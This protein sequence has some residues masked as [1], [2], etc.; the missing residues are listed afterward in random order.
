MEGF[1]YFKDSI[2]SCFRKTTGL[3]LLPRR[4]K[5]EG[6]QAPGGGEHEE[7]QFLL[8]SEVQNR[9]GEQSKFYGK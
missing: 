1:R 5:L 2:Y 9:F 7:Q 6:G 3:Y 4:R 8:Q